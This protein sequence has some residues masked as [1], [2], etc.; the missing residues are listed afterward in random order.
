MELLVSTRYQHAQEI[1][2]LRQLVPFAEWPAGLAMSLSLSMIQDLARGE[3][4]FR[5][6]VE[7]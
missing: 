3:V 5:L 4:H 1:K 7:T 2:Y 6:T